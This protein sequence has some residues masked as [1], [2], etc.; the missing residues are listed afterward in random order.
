MT[1]GSLRQRT[2]RLTEGLEGLLDLREDG[3]DP[4]DLQRR[5]FSDPVGF[6]RDVLGMDALWDKQEELARML[7]GNRLVRCRSAQGVGKSFVAAG[8]VLWWLYARGPSKVITVAPTERQVRELLW[9]EINRFWRLAGDL[10]GAIFQQALRIDD[11]LGWGAIGVVGTGADRLT[12]FHHPRLLVVIDEAHGCEN[13]VWEV[14]FSL[15]T[16]QD[17]AILAIGNPSA[18]SGKW[19]EIN[20]SSAWA[21]LTISALEHPNVVTG[22]DVIPGAVSRQSVEDF[23]REYGP[24]SPVY[25]SRVLAD[26]AE[27]DDLVLVEKDWV[28]ASFVTAETVR[29]AAEAHLPLSDFGLQRFDGWQDA[30]LTVGIDVARFG[31]D[32]SVC[33]LRRGDVVEG[34]RAWRGASTLDT[35]RRIARLLESER[36]TPRSTGYRMLVDEIG[37]GAGVVD[38]LREAGWRVTGVNIGAPAR[39]PAKFINRRAE[40][41]WRLRQMFEKGE[42]AVPANTGLQ[43][44]LAATRWSVE[45]NGKVRIEAKEDLRRRLGRS[46]DQADALALAF[47]GA[48]DATIGGAPPIVFF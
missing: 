4:G 35:A 10:R 16:G 44:E 43:E 30:P 8:L 36:L 20:Q 18:P 2:D 1:G 6:M 21:G 26:W 33:C 38:A 46:P 15:V 45:S 41:F 37:V 29:V 9:G 12:G 25:K 22:D 24:E 14:V 17:N 40:I 39:R 48:S 11:A 13:W 3:R 32:K 42:I 31:R 7:A 28:S 47:A 5:Y 27:A 23:R 34:F 19:Y